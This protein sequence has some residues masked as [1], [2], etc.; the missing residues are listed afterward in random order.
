[1]ISIEQKYLDR[2][3]TKHWYIFRHGLATHA[4]SYG[5]AILTADLL[6]EGLPAVE[7][8]AEYLKGKKCDAFYSSPLPRCLHTAEKVADKKGLT[9]TQDERL[10]EFHQ[11]TVE[12]FELRVVGF[13]TEIINNDDESVFICT[14]GIVIA[15]LKHLLLYGVFDMSDE[16]DFPPTASMF[17]IDNGKLKTH[18][19]TAT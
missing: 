15:A 11:E 13:L 16:M 19:F 6:P 3:R 9:P 2:A 7:K 18:V 1:M 12:E 17:E 5:D 10:R 8:L 14:H 4:R